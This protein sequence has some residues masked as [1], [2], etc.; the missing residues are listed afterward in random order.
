MDPNLLFC[1]RKIKGVYKYIIPT[2]KHHSE[3]VLNTKL[4]Y[5]FLKQKRLSI[6]V[7]F[8][9]F[10]NFLNGNFFNK[11]KLMS[12]KYR[13]HYLGRYALPEVYKNFKSYSS[14]RIYYFEIFKAFY[15]TAQVVDKAKNLKNVRAAF[16]DHGMYRNGIFMEI[17]SKKNIP[18]YSLGYP[19]GFF[20]FYNKKRKTLNY[21]NII[22][23]NK[24]KKINNSKNNQAK[25]AL[26]IVLTNT[27]KFPWMQHIRFVDNLK[28]NLKDLTHVIYVHSFTDTQMIYG[29]DGFLNVYEWFNFTLKELTKNKNNKILLKAHP[30][31]FHEKYPNKNAIY[32]RELFF[33]VTNQYLDNKNVI[34]LKDS[35]RNKKLLEQIPKKTI[36]VSHHGS[37]VLESLF[38]GFKCIASSS[39]FWNNQFKISNNWKN[40]IE[41]KK[42][43]K[44][45]WRLLKYHNKED[46]L[47]V[48]YQLFC[49]PK[50][51]YGKNYWENILIENL[52]IK[53]KSLFQNP[54]ET[55]EKTKISKIKKEKLI[56]K[57]SKS[58]ENIFINKVK[59]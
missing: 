58:I 13:G 54:V 11:D 17:L 19:R 32:D 10:K 24:A 42:I 25:K 53:K 34:I 18:I 57:I 59:I 27:E 46:L 22:Q 26:K 21:E 51:I 16:I 14:T 30:S 9:I 41:Y 55:L 52:K 35:I 3:K 5:S 31:F 1:T 29:Y 44:K 38:M 15:F 37:V 6:N 43:L 40:E 12:I 4:E 8:F 45:E 20:F 56:S 50:G 47:N 23:L 33:K 49:E 36:L 2:V 28:I 39:A 48:S 7:L